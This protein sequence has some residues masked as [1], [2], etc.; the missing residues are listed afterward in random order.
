LGRRDTGAAG[1][2]CIR[3]GGHT[4]RDDLWFDTRKPRTLWTEKKT[5]F[6]HKRCVPTQAFTSAGL[7]PSKRGVAHKG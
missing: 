3:C 5:E 2:E 4:R 1:G 7:R 6:I